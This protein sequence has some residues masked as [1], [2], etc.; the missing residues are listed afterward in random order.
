MAEDPYRAPTPPPMPPTHPAPRAADDAGLRLLVPIGRS[1]LAIAAGY[2][3]LISLVLIPAP[4]AIVVSI[5][6][7]RDIRHSK[8]TGKPKF[9]MGRAVFGLIMG[10]LGTLAL[11]A[12]LISQLTSS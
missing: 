4:I 7:I 2:L 5:L 8:S 3:G 6:A 10:T 9:G 1:G 11:A 12:I